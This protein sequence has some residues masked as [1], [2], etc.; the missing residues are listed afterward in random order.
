MPNYYD[1]DWTPIT[2]EEW[3]AKFTDDY[4]RVDY[5]K[6][7]KDTYV[8]TVWLWLEHGRDGDGN[9]LIFE[10]MAFSD[11]KAID[12]EM[13]RG[14]TLEEAEINHFHMCSMVKKVLL[15]NEE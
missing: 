13:R 3:V 11:N 10:T 4:K 2:L 12:W 9:P 15:A 1:K 14:S 7:N 8:S 5:T 6:F